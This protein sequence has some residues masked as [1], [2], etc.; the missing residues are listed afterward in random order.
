[1]PWGTY[2]ANW[3]KLTSCSN[4]KTLRNG[5]LNSQIRKGGPAAPAFP[6]LGPII[7]KL[8][9]YLLNVLKHVNSILDS[10]KGVAP[11]AEFV[12]D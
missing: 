7:K 8:L 3:K 10:L 9:G 2:A 5:G 1:M 6:R 12:K 4:F 11:P